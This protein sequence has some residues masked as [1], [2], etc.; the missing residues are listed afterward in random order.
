MILQWHHTFVEGRD[1][2]A[3]TQHGRRPASVTSPVNVNT[4]SVVIKEDRHLSKRKIARLLNM[5]QSSVHRIPRQYLQMQRVPSMLVP[6]FLTHEQMDSRLCLCEE[7][8]E[9]I[10]EDPDYLDG[11]TTVD[12]NCIHHHDPLS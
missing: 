6:H 5:T 4:V 11:V 7:A 2:V 12:E 3:L 8:L 10:A 9:R 1:L